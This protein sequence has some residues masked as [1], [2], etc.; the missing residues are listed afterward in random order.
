MDTRTV[1]SAY[2]RVG[3]VRSFYIDA[4]VFHKTPLISDGY[5]T[6]GLG[7]S[8]SRKFGYWIGLGTGPYDK[9]GLVIKTD[10]GIGTNFSLNL[11]GRLSSSEDISESAINVGVSYRVAQRDKVPFSLR[12]LITSR[13]ARQLFESFAANFISNENSPRIIK[14]KCCLIPS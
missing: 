2:L 14:R 9:A 1:P 5:F 8:R 6:L 4:S 3:N 7:A 12:T 10:F 13:Y 11:S